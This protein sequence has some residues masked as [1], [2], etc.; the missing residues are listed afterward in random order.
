MLDEKHTCLFGMLP[1]EATP[2]GGHEQWFARD[3]IQEAKRVRM[4]SCASEGRFVYKTSMRAM[5]RVGKLPEAFRTAPLNS[6]QTHALAFCR[7]AGSHRDRDNHHN[8]A[9]PFLASPALRW[10]ATARA[11]QGRPAA[12]PALREATL[13]PPRRESSDD[14]PNKTC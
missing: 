13:A 7:M 14:G 9:L 8:G 1:G 4:Q 10:P 11:P 5:P 3:R 6:R 12:H 2:T